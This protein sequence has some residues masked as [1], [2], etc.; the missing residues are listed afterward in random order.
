M[1]SG[2]HPDALLGPA[3]VSARVLGHP[4]ILLGGPRALLLQVA[5]PSVA[6]GVVAHSDFDA[7]PYRRLARTFEVMHA[8]S[9]GGPAESEAA[10]RGLAAVHHRVRGTTGAGTPYS[11]GDGALGLWVHATLVDTA[12]AVERR[13]LGE[14]DD[15]GRARFYDESRRLAAPLGLSEAAVPGDLEAFGAYMASM[16]AELLDGPAGADAARIARRVLHPPA[17]PRLGLLAPLGAR[18]AAR[19]VRSV[20]IDLGPPALCRAFGLDEDLDAASAKALVAFAA[21]S[22][23]AS[24]RLPGSVRDPGALVRLTAHLAD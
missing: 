9:F 19:L 12:M 7:D 10:A 22:R 14:L 17:T 8:I 1:A 3:S 6:A 16:E 24:P 20:T 5:H 18:A 11:A 4:A 15:E 23:A 13:Y 21:A 2:V